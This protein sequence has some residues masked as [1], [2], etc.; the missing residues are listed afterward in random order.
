MAIN[1]HDFHVFAVS[2]VVALIN[3]MS[4]QK[5]GSWFNNDNDADGDDDDYDEKM[6]GNN[7]N[8]G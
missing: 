4:L 2:F 3:G 1:I 6:D 8:N 5:C 7:T